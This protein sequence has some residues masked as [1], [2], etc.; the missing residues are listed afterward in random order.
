MLTYEEF[1][2][3]LKDAY[4]LT[5]GKIR[6][7]ISSQLTVLEG[8]EPKKLIGDLKIILEKLIKKLSCLDYRSLITANNEERILPLLVKDF[9]GI[10]RFDCVMTPDNK[11]KIVEINSEY[12]DGLLMHDYTYSTLLGKKITKNLDV[13]L[14]LFDKNETIFIMF[15]KEAVF[16]DAYYLEYK[17][18]QKAGFRCFIGNPEDL[19]FKGE[20]IYCKGHKIECIR[21]CMETPKFHQGFLDRLAGKKIRLVNT[22]DMRVLGYKSSLQFIK[23]TYVPRTFWLTSANCNEVIDNKNRFVI[24]P[25]NMYEGKGVF[26]GCD[27][28]KTDWER[29]V[30]SCVN[31]NYIVQD[32]IP[33]KE[34]NVKI[35]RDQ[36]I[37]NERLFFD[38][39]P[40]FFVKNGR[41][42][43]NGL[44]LMR[45]SRKKILNVAQGGGIGYL[46]Y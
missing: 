21:R 1:W 33:A 14:K 36:T 12:P 28:D 24:K 13:F 22:F 26:L 3:Q 23:S 31:K 35:Y 27:T 38:V 8:I 15:Q 34:I 10:V 4:P 30:V 41:V 37:S 19:S 45:F 18:L 20:F 2:Q 9:T 16:K 43:G 44:V 25:S 29:T 11:V 6:L 32:L 39:C 17:L 46:K 7:P 5:K 40:H 42:I